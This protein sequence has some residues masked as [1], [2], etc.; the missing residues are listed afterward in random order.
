[1]KAISKGRESIPEEQKLGSLKIRTKPIGNHIFLGPTG[2][3]KTQLAKSSFGKILFD[4]TII[5]VQDRYEVIYGEILSL[6]GFVGAPSRVC[7]VMR[8][9]PTY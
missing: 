2:V 5:W 1:M 7:R 3:G 6:H 4:T 9:W 8:R